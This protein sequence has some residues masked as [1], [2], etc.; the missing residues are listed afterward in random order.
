MWTVGKQ[1][2]LTRKINKPF[3]PNFNEKPTSCVQ[4]STKPQVVVTG[5]SWFMVVPDQLCTN[6]CFSHTHALLPLV[7]K[8]YFPCVKAISAA[9]LESTNGSNM[10][11]FAFTVADEMLTISKIFSAPSTIE[12][13]VWA[14]WLAKFEARF[15]LYSYAS[16]MAVASTSVEGV[17][18]RAMNYSH[19]GIFLG[20]GL[21]L[22][23]IKAAARKKVELAAGRKTTWDYDF[24]EMWVC[25]R[26]IK[27]K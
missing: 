26:I 8:W 24:N 11:V 1:N 15:G 12:S 18:A 25:H 16:V 2:N 10:F 13:C 27:N 17:I 5:W 20:S 7:Y 4:Y 14:K 21:T 3:F 9:L 6:G 23:Q 19:T 22:P